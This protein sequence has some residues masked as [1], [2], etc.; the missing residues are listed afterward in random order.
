M[1]TLLHFSTYAL[2]LGL[3]LGAA[4]TVLAQSNTSSLKDKMLR[5]L[6]NVQNIFEAQYA[7]YEWKAE[8]AQW[9]LQQKMDEARARVQALENPRVL[10]YRKI[11]FD[12]FQSTKDFHVSV[13]FW[14]T[15]KSGLPFS[16]LPS[17]GRY[18]ISYID[19]GQLAEESFPFQVGDELVSL[20]DETAAQAVTRLKNY[21]GANSPLTDEY[22]AAQYLTAPNAQRG[23]PIPQGTV[24][25]GVR[26][27]TSPADAAPEI[28]QLTWNYVREEVTPQPPQVAGL[29]ERY[30]HKNMRVAFADDFDKK[31]QNPFLMGVKKSYVPELGA[32][33]WESDANSIF[34]A[35]IYRDSQRR[36][37]GFVRIPSYV[38][39]VGNDD[40]PKYDAAIKE[41]RSLVERFQATTDALVIDQVNNP[42]GSVFYLYTL[43]SLLSDRAMR[44]PLHRMTITQTDVADAVQVRNLLSTVTT[45]EQAKEKLGATVAGYPVDYTFARF[46]L[47]SAERT[48]EDWNN[49]LKLSPYR[50]I[51]GVDEIS[52]DP[53]HYTKAIL[54]LTNPLDF[55]GGD[56]FPTILQD[57]RRARILGLTT[58]GAGGYVLEASYPNEFGIEKM[59][60][61]GSLAQRVNGRP[62]ENLG[63]QPDREYQVSPEDLRTNYAPYRRV[64]EEELNALI[65][66]Q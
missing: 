35:A 31:S 39:P 21:L 64:I 60:V 47:E 5:D 28:R 36:N 19:R 6:G 62:I 53:T 33:V 7:P 43:V 25:V 11:L 51:F 14:T 13:R 38:P 3:G 56:F 4:G 18:Y 57:N 40:Q 45:T 27:A 44:T 41:F 23:H 9:N 61:T 30:F 37:I 50:F 42:G 1:K 52:P 49:G 8:F 12:F 10:D 22:L 2:T 48:I 15:E 29:I 65:V 59:R 54:L 58:A 16:V 46:A 26:R 63:V 34:N 24:R 17:G 55:S 66:P 32:K 20:G